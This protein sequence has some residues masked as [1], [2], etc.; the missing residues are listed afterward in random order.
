MIFENYRTLCSLFCRKF[1][2][3]FFSNATEVQNAGLPMVR[4]QI[5]RT[6]SHFVDKENS[7]QGLGHLFI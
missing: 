3:S 6:N 2:K 7:E 1:A 4:S 5:K